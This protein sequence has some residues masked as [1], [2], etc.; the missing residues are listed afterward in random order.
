MSSPQSYWDVEGEAR[1]HHLYML[2]TTPPWSA[3][4]RLAKGGSIEA[5]GSANVGHWLLSGV[6]DSV[7]DT[8]FK[9]KV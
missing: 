5:V 6:P 8:P 2:G 1:S 4:L 3:R 7:K 9:L